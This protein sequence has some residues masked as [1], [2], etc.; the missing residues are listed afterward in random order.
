MN[1]Y[2]NLLEIQRAIHEYEGNIDPYTFIAQLSERFIKEHDPMWGEER[3]D[4]PY[5]DLLFNLMEIN[6]IEF[7]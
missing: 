2:I 4:D 7:Y 6:G 3:E 1:K 5:T